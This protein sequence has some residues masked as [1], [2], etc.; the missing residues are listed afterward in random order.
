MKRMCLVCNGEKDVQ[1]M[2]LVD[3]FYICDTKE[4]LLGALENTI[5]ARK[6][7]MERQELREG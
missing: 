4:C 1:D 3:D 7:S 2:V 5:A 6:F